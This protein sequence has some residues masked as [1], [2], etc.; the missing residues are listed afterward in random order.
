MGC[1]IKGFGIVDGP[2]RKEQWLKF[3]KKKPALI[4][5]VF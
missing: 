4:Q 1:G 3:K 5:L 2:E